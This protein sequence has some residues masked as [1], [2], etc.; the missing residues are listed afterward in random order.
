MTPA[1]LRRISGNPQVLLWGY[2]LLIALAELLTSS[3]YPQAGLLFHAIILIGL[4]LH[5]AL[6]RNEQVRRLALA[7]V[8]APLIRLLS[9]SLPIAAFPQATWHPIISIPLLIAAWMIARQ[10]HISRRDIG[11]R[12]GNPLIQCMLISGGITLGALEYAILSPTDERLAT[13]LLLAP[14]WSTFFLTSLSLFVFTGFTEEIIFRGLFQSLAMPVL[15]RWG[16]I[17]VSLLF[18]ALH[19]TYRSW[20]DFVFVTIVGL[21]FAYIVMWSDSILGVTLAHGL[22]NVMLLV[23]LP[24]IS[25]HT[26]GPIATLVYW[27]IWIGTGLWLI[28]FGMLMWRADVEGRLLL[29]DQA[30]MYE[31]GA[32]PGTASNPLWRSSQRQLAA[33]GPH[34]QGTRVWRQL[35]SRGAIAR[36]NRIPWSKLT[37]RVTLAFMLGGLFGILGSAGLLLAFGNSR[38]NQVAAPAATSVAIAEATPTTLATALAET[39]TVRAVAVVVPT[40]NVAPTPNPVVTT[41]VRTGTN[42]YDCPRTGRCPNGGT[43]GKLAVA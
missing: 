6:E 3:A 18:G 10:L 32:P 20:S 9:L 21:I 33:I 17:Y 27:S 5:G 19:I 35:E 12:I 11:L 13:G 8:L 29:R 43:G 22:T 37:P 26:T 7:L 38:A 2:L 24:Y 40:P 39:P 41:T 25:Q 16:L 14:T 34:V 30:A 28:A 36:V 31:D 15:R 4:L 1:A 42:G 23:V